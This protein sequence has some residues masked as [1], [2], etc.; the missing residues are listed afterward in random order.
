VGEAAEHPGTTHARVWLRSTVAI[1]AGAMT[2]TGIAA[3]MTA[4]AATA[5]SDATGSR[6]ATVNV[7]SLTPT[8]PG[9]S[10]TIKV[11]GTVTNDSGEPITGAH[12]GLR[13]GAN[14]PLIS[15][16]AIGNTASSGNFSPLA[17]GEEVPR[18]TLNLPDIPPHVSY[19][20]TLDM[21]VS[22]LKLGREGVY[23]VGI[24]ASGTTKDTGYE[25]VVGIKRTFLPWYGHSSGRKTQTTLLWPLIDQPRMDIR[26]P[27]GD[28]Q[29]PPL[30]RDDSLARELA[31]GG[32]LQQMV[33]LGEKL[34]VTWVVDPDLL[35]TVDAMTHP[36]KVLGPGGDATHTTNG[37]GSAYAKQWL[38]E[39]QTAVQGKQIVALPFGDPDL[40]SI[41]H[42]G[43]SVPGTIAHLK[44]ATDLS[45]V[46]V[47]TVLGVTPR[48]DFAWPV[49][50]AVD[51]SIVNTAT[52]GGA[53]KIIARSDS[54]RETGQLPYTPTAARPIGGG[55]TAIVADASLSNAF[56]GDLTSAGASTLAVQRY[57]AQSM[58]I[59]EQ[60]PGKSRSVLVAPQRMPTAAQA[61]AMATA[62]SAATKGGWTT[63]IPL[64]AAVDRTPDPAANQ[65]VPSSRQYP[66]ALRRQELSTTAFKK[67][68]S[69]QSSL[70]SF[71]VILSLK[72]RVTTPFGNAVM[73]SMSTQWRGRTHD[74]TAFREDISSYLGDLT[75]DVHILKKQTVTLSGR[76]ATVPVTVEN[77]LAQ[78]VSGLQLRLISTQSNR[79]NPGLPQTVDIDGGHSRSLKFDTTA[80]ANGLAS[81]TAQLYTKDGVPYGQ[82]MNFQVNVTSI[83]DTVMLVIAGGLLL[84]VL[85]GVRMYRQR[86]RLALR[87]AQEQDPDAEGAQAAGAEETGRESAA[88]GGTGEPQTPRSASQNMTTVPEQPGDPVPDTATEDVDP[89]TTG[90]KVDR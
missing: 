49:D 88:D 78:R 29:Q 26:S 23:E 44:S 80:H 51:P 24:T 56:S 45:S 18:H 90:E 28:D 54:F 35:A 74:A 64:G 12:V 13:V 6:A 71:V 52:A 66:S 40:A 25:H 50:G 20:F 43:Q 3:P 8:V 34:P 9:K 68:Q 22:A 39:L 32:R 83:T 10:A 61:Q 55:S 33:S 70:N 77:N 21:P 76:S 58:M 53:D 81:V 85:A 89:P 67:I 46:T 17:D 7:D 27:S 47:Q 82:P 48:T 59:Y 87:A 30:F 75:D 1:L 16:N 79:L 63:P 36:Y 2:L 86:K 37:T 57:L 4:S 19:P 73:R 15:R 65:T 11:K 31:P 62:F 42:R 14:G 41:A 69:V 72:G 38:N 5:A 84:L 60:A